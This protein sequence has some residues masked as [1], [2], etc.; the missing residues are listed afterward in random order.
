MTTTQ[1]AAVTDPTSTADRVRLVEL[2]VTMAEGDQSAVFALVEEFGGSIAAVIRGQ[3]A[4]YGRR[5][6]LRDPEEVTGLVHT[7]AFEILDRAGAWD[8]TGAPPWVWARRAIRAAVVTQI[9]H[10]VAEGD[11]DRLAG[12]LGGGQG[13]DLDDVLAVD[14][15]GDLDVDLDR[16]AVSN[17]R[18]G[19]LLDALTAAASRRDQLVVRQ[20]LIQKAL[21]D[22]SPSH[23]VAAE[24]GLSPDNVRQ[25]VRRV[26]R[27]VRALQSTDDRYRALGGSGWLAA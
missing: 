24:L 23:T 21:G 22:P 27:R 13:G 2:M 7:A 6:L 17:P 10:A 11:A 1:P 8:P 3:L 25:I 12:D 14:L 9:G 19:L 20:F 18:V 5:D 15:D 4:S 16:L 26:R